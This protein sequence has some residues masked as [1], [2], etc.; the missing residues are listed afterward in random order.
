MDCERAYSAEYGYM[1]STKYMATWQ[2][3]AAVRAVPR[4]RM[5]PP[6][7][8]WPDGA[9]T[10]DNLWYVRVTYLL[11]LPADNAQGK[12][13][14]SAVPR[15]FINQPTKQNAPRACMRQPTQTTTTTTIVVLLMPTSYSL[16]SPAY[17][18]SP[19]VARVSIRGLQAPTA[20]QSPTRRIQSTPSTH[21]SASFLRSVRIHI[22]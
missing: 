6:L 12:K 1:A 11:G 9:A 17:A 18:S 19:I 4:G 7:A 14:P 8:R 3:D 22:F 5:R 16:Q 10:A 20:T 13:P 2:F 15:C 21:E